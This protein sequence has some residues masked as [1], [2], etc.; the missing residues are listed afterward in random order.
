MSVIRI[1][2]KR[3]SRQERIGFSIRRHR[4]IVLWSGHF[5]SRAL[6][7][8]PRTGAKW[9]VGPR[10]AGKLARRWLA[11]GEVAGI[12]IRPVEVDTAAPGRGQADQRELSRD[13]LFGVTRREL[14]REVP[15]LEPHPDPRDAGGFW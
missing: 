11:W 2:L 1:D 10:D 12:G 3:E 6:C 13:Y 4:F 8:W 9:P 5:S 14:Q 7:S 15:V